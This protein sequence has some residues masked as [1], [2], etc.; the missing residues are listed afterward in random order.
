MMSEI[1]RPFLSQ[2][3]AT[4][5]IKSFSAWKT[6]L[7][8]QSSELPSLHNSK[9]LGRDKV[10]QTISESHHLY[11]QRI[12][13]GWGMTG[14]AAAHWRAL[15]C[16]E[17]HCSRSSKAWA[18]GELAGPHG[19]LTVPLTTP[20]AILA[21]KMKTNMC[22]ALLKGALLVSFSST[23]ASSVTSASTHLQM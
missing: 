5:I 11:L 16:V 10:S 8:V 20:D 6:G 18:M 21:S 22:D 14:W 9:R 3:E 23:F 7:G 1:A 12:R 13:S 15:G 2:V 4:A 19:L 17:S